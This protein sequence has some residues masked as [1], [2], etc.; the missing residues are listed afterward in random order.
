M[1]VGTRLWFDYKAIRRKESVRLVPTETA[2]QETEDPIDTVFPGTGST[3]EGVKGQSST[4][5]P[6]L[7]GGRR[8]IA[9]NPKCRRK[10]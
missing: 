3:Q 5:S 8:H 9:F 4:G 7:S 6:H 10:G 1:A 2:E